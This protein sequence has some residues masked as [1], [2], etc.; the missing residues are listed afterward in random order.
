MLP[1]VAVNLVPAGLLGPRKPQ[2]GWNRTCGLCLGTRKA[3]LG[4]GVPVPHAGSCGHRSRDSLVSCLEP[5]GFGVVP[6]SAEF[7]AGWRLGSR[8]L[9]SEPFGAGPCWGC[10]TLHFPLGCLSQARIWEA[11]T[12]YSDSCLFI[13]DWQ[14]LWE[15]EAAGNGEG[16]CRRGLSISQAPRGPG[17]LVGSGQEA[18]SSNGTSVKVTRGSVSW[19]DLEIWKHSRDSPAHQ[20]PSELS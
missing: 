4:L 19:P 10:R 20:S 15:G 16:S 5:A 7:Y 8:G 6:S 2:P 13:A 14:V 3:C 11:F 17:F 12:I 18:A 1:R 9:G